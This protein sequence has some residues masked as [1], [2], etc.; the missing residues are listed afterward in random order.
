MKNILKEDDSL[1]YNKWVKGIADREFSA[2][3]TI[4]NDLVKNNP[5]EQYP[6]MKRSQ[7]VLPYPLSNLIPALGNVIVGLNSS[8]TML[9]ELKLNP[10]VKKE[11][12]NEHIQSSI[13]KLNQAAELIK[14]AVKCVDNID[15][16][17]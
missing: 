13:K 17:I 9:K 8:V 4:V 12:N 5:T 10:L 2:Q 15:S 3:K 14:D 1:N 6:N 11:S 16:S 7:N